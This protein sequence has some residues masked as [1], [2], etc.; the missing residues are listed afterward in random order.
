MYGRNRHLNYF[1]SVPVSWRKVHFVAYKICDEWRHQ[2]STKKAHSHTP[3]QNYY[4][5]AMENRFAFGDC[6]SFPISSRLCSLC[7]LLFLPY[8][9]NG[10]DFTFDDCRIS[11]ASWLTVKPIV[12]GMKCKRNCMWIHRDCLTFVTPVCWALIAVGERVARRV[13]TRANTQ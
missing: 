2:R 13:E 4:Q 5:N 9:Q 10:N 7:H 6:I 12:C 11:L 8:I 1:D 3:I